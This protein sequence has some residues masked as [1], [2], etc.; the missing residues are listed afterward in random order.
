[1]KREMRRKRQQLPPERCADILRRMTSGVLAVTD[2]DGEPYAVPLSYVYADGMIYFHSAPVGH[3]IEAISGCPKV[4]FCVVEKDDVSAE[5]YTTLFRSVIVF[6][7]AHVINDDCEKLR[8]L[9]LLADKYS[10]GE[11]GRRRREVEKGFDR[12]VMVA[13]TV[14]R[15]TGKEAVEFVRSREHG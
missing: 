14:E 10:P 4:S 8:T 9:N 6:G 7:T 2:V 12:L 3:K 5:E 13:I 1:M 11:T 15:M